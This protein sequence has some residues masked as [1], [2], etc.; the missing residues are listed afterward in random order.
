MPEHDFYTIF[1]QPIE[2]LNIEYMVTGSIAAIFYGQPRL[3]HDIDIVIHLR[4]QD[5]DEFCNTFPLEKFYCP[6]SEII[7][8]EI[9]REQHAHFNLIHHKSGLKADCYPFSGDA[10][11][12]WAFQNI[13]KINIDE[14]SSLNLAP[15]EYVIIRKLQFYRDGGSKKHLQD[16][17]AMIEISGD[18][19]DKNFLGKELKNRGL[20]NFLNELSVKL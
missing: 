18:K 14:N 3:T 16:I 6:P 9:R 1:I 19:I 15:P 12:A 17:A 5:I 10:L 2:K 20:K 11:H 7:Q 8:I 4:S 13:R